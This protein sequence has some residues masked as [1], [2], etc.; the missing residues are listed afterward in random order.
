M[1]TTVK[2]PVLRQKYLAFG[3]VSFM[4]AFCSP[5]PHLSIKMCVAVNPPMVLCSYFTVLTDPSSCETESTKQI[6]SGGEVNRNEGL[7]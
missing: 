6:G 4:S 5:A 2:L 1:N 3:S 7:E